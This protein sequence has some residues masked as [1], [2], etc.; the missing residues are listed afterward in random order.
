MRL[1]LQ[2]IYFVASPKVLLRVKEERS[3]SYTHRQSNLIGHILFR[4]CLLKHFT[5]G[6]IEGRVQVTVR[7]GRRRKQPLDDLKEQGGY[8]KLKK[9]AVCEELA[10]DEAVTEERLE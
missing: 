8:R 2:N 7:R 1:H 3:I 5:E 4:N 6:K 10:A 9:E